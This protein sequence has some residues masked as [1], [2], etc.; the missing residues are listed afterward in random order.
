MGDKDEVGAWIKTTAIKRYLRSQIFCN[1]LKGCRWF[2]YYV[3][4]HNP[5]LFFCLGGFLL[6]FLFS[7]D[8]TATNCPRGAAAGKMSFFVFALR[9]QKRVTQKIGT[10]EENF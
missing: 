8:E 5:V 2:L 3:S 7:H 1:I 9:S 6:F 4:A 10:E